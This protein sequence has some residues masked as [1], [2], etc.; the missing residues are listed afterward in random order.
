MG[1]NIFLSVVSIIPHLSWRHED[2]EDGRRKE[3]G[4]VNIPGGFKTQAS[5]F[6]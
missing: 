6:S 5:L 3:D 2:V 4:E 1:K